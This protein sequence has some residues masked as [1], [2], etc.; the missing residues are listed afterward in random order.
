MSKYA[1]LKNLLLILSWKEFELVGSI[2]DEY[3]VSV[4]FFSFECFS[5]IVFMSRFHF[6]ACDFI[7]PQRSNLLN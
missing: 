2:Y 4:R 5:L 6:I 3:P 1:L 7:F